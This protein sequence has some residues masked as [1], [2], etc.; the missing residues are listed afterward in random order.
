MAKS[1]SFG[2]NLLHA[3][4]RDFIGFLLSVAERAALCRKTPSRFSHTQRRLRI[5]WHAPEVGVGG[6]RKG[7]DVRYVMVQKKRRKGRSRGD[8]AP[9]AEKCDFSENS[10]AYMPFTALLGAVR[11]AVVPVAPRTRAALTLR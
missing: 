10:E 11:P 4:T 6:I 8:E 3:V 5:V 1:G 2:A 7:Y 9:D